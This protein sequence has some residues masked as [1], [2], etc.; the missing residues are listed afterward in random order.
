MLM[1]RSVFS[2]HTH[3]QFL[4][5][6]AD[7]HQGSRIPQTPEIVP[8]TPKSTCDIDEPKTM[9]YVPEMSVYLLPLSYIAFDTFRNLKNGCALC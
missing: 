8:S 6:T 7:L 3:Y 1:Q 4:A 2:W 9:S 5:L